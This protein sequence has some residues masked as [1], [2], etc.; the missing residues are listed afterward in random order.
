MLSYL[1]TINIYIYIVSSSFKYTAPPHCS[2]AKTHFV[3]LLPVCSPMLPRCQP[4]PTLV[5][6]ID[7][8]QIQPRPFVQQESD[9]NPMAPYMAFPTA[10]YASLS[11]FSFTCSV[12]VHP[13]TLARQNIYNIAV[14][15]AIEYFI[16]IWSIVITRQNS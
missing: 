15:V 9:A 8:L 6:T 16:N 2:R 3:L 14:H 10:Y 4:L 1:A 11:Y 7:F 13:L 5:L 12:R